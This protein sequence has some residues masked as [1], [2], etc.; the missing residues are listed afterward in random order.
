MNKTI[1]QIKKLFNRQFP[2]NFLVRRP[3]WGSLIFFIILYFFVVVYH[4][5]QVHKA[6]S[7]SFSFTMLG[8][9]FLVTIM[10]LGMSAIIKKTN[11]FSKTDNWTVSKE[12]LSVVIILMSIGISAYFS[13]FVMENTASRWNM[14]TFIDSFS[15]SVAIGIIPVLFPSLLNIRYAFTPEV[16]QEY[17]TNLPDSQRETGEKLI[18]IKSRAKKEELSFLPEEFIY[19][20]SDGNYVVF[21]L[22][23]QGKTIDVIIRNSISEIEHQLQAIPFFIRIHRAFIVNLEKV[24]SKKGNSLGYRVQV[25]GSNKIVPVSRQNT[26]KFDELTR[27]YLLSIH[28]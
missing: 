11:C 22:I 13:G 4:P 1:Q 20:E 14:S 5:L 15:R 8:Y 9:C 21:H 25:E 6:A 27:Q 17:K 2:R 23:K 10:A 12:L 3:L 7:F 19:A 26:Q 16:F 18:H 28:P 24:S